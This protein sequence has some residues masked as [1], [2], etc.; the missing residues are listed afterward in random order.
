MRRRDF[1][2]LVGGAALFGPTSAQ[3]QRPGVPTIGFLSG[4]SRSGTSSLDG[5]RQ[6]L[7]EAGYVEGRN[8]T[9]EYRWADAHF[10]R[11]AGLAEEL[12][13][14][15]VGL[16][17]TVTLPAAMA[18]QSASP[19]TAVVFVIGEDPVKAGLVASLDRPGGNATGVSDF[20]N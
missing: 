20:I 15:R 1:V 16:I 5:L 11:L 8:L 9:I 12:V 3:A 10:E 18:A 6:G 19:T 2:R 13:S 4:A 14:R 7:A 17:A